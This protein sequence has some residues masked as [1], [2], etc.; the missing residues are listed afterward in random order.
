VYK[1]GSPAASARP[2]AVAATAPA[3]PRQ[4]AVAAPARQPASALRFLSEAEIR[5]TVIGNTLNFVAPSNGLNMYVYF[6]EDGTAETKL[7]GQ[8]ARTLRKKWF[9]NPKGL[10]CRTVGKQNRNHCTRVQSTSDAKTLTLLNQQVRYPA[11]VLNGRN[12]AQ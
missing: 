9:F 6:A 5:G 8:G 11:T 4:V 7:T 3:K 12:F 1:L 10:L 2:R